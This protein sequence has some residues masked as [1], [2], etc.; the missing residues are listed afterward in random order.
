MKISPK[1]LTYNVFSNI[2]CLVVLAFLVLAATPNPPA[3]ASRALQVTTNLV[4]TDTNFFQANTGRLGATL[5]TMGIT[6]GGGAV[7]SNYSVVQVGTLDNTNIAI[8]RGKMFLGGITSDQEPTTYPSIFEMLH[9]VTSA[10]VG[11]S[12]FVMTDNVLDDS[13]T[14][15]DN[16]ALRGIIRQTTLGNS[17]IRAGEFHAVRKVGDG[18]KFTWGIEVGVHTDIVS[19]GAGVKDANTGIYIASSHTGW[20][21]TGV[22]ADSG[23]WVTGEDG[24]TNGFRYTDTDGVTDLFTVERRGGVTGRLFGRFGNSTNA[25]GLTSISAG[26]PVGLSG[27]EISLDP[28]DT[29][30]FYFR[31]YQS[32]VAFRNL[33]IQTDA[34]EVYIGP[35]N[36]IVV[37]PRTGTSVIGVGIMTPSPSN[38]FHV[39]GNM[40]VESATNNTTGNKMFFLTSVPTSEKGIQFLMGSNTNVF[41]IQHIFAGNAFFDIALSPDGGA[42]GIG[43]GSSNPLDSSA[44]L[45]LKSTTKGLLLPRMTKAQR[46]A[47]SAPTDGLMVYQTDSTIGL[48][49]RTSGAWNSLVGTADP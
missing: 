47:I 10:D 45:E 23:V 5:G 37:K 20:G 29:N 41:T 17:H 38:T 21:V 25:G 33:K 6:S 26:L 8:I 44:L 34:G 12:G 30:A 16:G 15:R 48:H 14:N 28:N 46:N 13:T 4:L 9:T 22:R 40:R 24:W 19:A 18:S 7:S 39:A 27:L 3:P 42:V 49:V 1:K 11:S 2:Y 36:A 35:T 31:H 32:G 43:T